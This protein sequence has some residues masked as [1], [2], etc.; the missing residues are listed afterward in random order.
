MKGWEKFELYLDRALK[1]CEAILVI[2][3]TATLLGLIVFETG[4]ILSRCPQERIKSTLTMLNEN[5]KVGLLLLVPLF[6]RT[7]RMFLERV[8]KFLGMERDPEQVVTQTNPERT[9]SGQPNPSAEAE[10]ED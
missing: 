6:Y 10:E 7:V 5:W 3:L 9:K 2:C 1:A 4:W 8:R